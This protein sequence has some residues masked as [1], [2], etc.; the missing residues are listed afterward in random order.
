M[1][2]IEANLL[3]SGY[4]APFYGQESDLKANQPAARELLAKTRLISGTPFG[5]WVY[6][7]YV[8]QSI[9]HYQQTS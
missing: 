4:A 9:E 8:A 7:H 5:E 3:G 6:N 2:T 1:A